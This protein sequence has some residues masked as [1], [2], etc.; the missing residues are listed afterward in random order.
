MHTSR[1]DFSL[2]GHDSFSQVLFQFM[3]T[4]FSL[5][6]ALEHNGLKKYHLKKKLKLRKRKQTKRI[7]KFIWRIVFFEKKKPI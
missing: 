3:K 4:Q 6:R 7:F 2:A 5:L 1:I